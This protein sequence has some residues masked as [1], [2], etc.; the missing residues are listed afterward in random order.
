MRRMM[1]TFALAVLVVLCGCGGDSGN[2]GTGGGTGGAGTG[3]G[4]GGGNGGA[5]SGVFSCDT[6]IA[7]V[8]NCADY[9]WTGGVY[10]TST[11]QSACTG[12]G[13]TGGTGCSHSNAVGG[14]KV[15]SSAGAVSISTTTWYYSGGGTTSGTVSQACSIAGGT[16]VNP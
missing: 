12:S 2:S 16:V 9:S 15:T 6:Q 10:T 14:C 3:G 7:T 13:G 4:N 1:T 5:T 8:H 11:W